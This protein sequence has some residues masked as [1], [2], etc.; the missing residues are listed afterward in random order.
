MVKIKR[1]AAELIEV[2]FNTLPSFALGF[3]VGFS[4]FS[5]MPATWYNVLLVLGVCFLSGIGLAALKDIVQTSYRSKKR[6]FTIH[7]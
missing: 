6:V 4:L 2:L 1:F 7:E 5:Q 3:V